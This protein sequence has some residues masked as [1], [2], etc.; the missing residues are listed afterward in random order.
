MEISLKELEKQRR[1]AVRVRGEVPLPDVPREV[2]QVDALTPVESD[3]VAE[4]DED[5]CRLHGDLHTVVTYQCSRCLEPFQSSLT[6]P[7]D[8][9]FTENA[10][11]ADGEDI[12][13]V[14]DDILVLDPYIEQAIHLALEY[15]PL[16]D[17]ACKGL[18]PECG[19]NRNIDP[20]QC[21]TRRIDPRLEALRDLLSSTD[22]E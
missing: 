17:E 8:E 12:H 3:L 1:H 16:C 18:C 19:R 20:C 2:R 6:A 13:H 10:R 5:V 4:W 14:P 9:S 22:S 7:F 11:K 21:D 15:R